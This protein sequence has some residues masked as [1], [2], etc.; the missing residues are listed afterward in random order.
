MYAGC[1]LS[2]LFAV[3]SAVVSPHCIYIYIYVALSMHAPNFC[4]D[5][6]PCRSCLTC[7]WEILKVCISVF[8][9]FFPLLNHL[10]FLHMTAHIHSHSIILSFCLPLC[11]R[12][13]RRERPRTVSQEQ[14]HAHP[15][16]PRQRGSH[17][18]GETPS[19]SSSMTTFLPPT[20]R[21]SHQFFKESDEARGPNRSDWLSPD[22]PPSSYQC[23]WLE[24]WH[25]PMNRCVR[26][27][28]EEAAS[29]TSQSVPTVN[30]QQAVS[31]PRSCDCWGNEMPVS[32]SWLGQCAEL[33]R[34][35]VWV[36]QSRRLFLP[37][38]LWTVQVSLHCYIFFFQV[39]DADVKLS[40]WE[41]R[42][43]SVI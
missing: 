34:L 8:F 17:P 1:H 9:F 13:F 2:L 22:P 16:H 4:T 5:L 37:Q 38:P 25:S 42:L 19:I 26:F 41:Q 29:L 10:D 43:L 30:K 28:Q 3:H 7:T 27:A 14:H 11:L 40:A 39:I 24:L 23:T 21:I 35:L 36:L 15:V 20:S 32:N 33:C 6:C 31:L 12:F 18:P